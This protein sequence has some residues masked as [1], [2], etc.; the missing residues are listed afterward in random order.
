MTLY[1]F[2]ASGV[3]SSIVITVALNRVVVEAEKVNL[4][5]ISYLKLVPQM[6]LVFTQKI[7]HTHGTVL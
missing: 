6:G 3:S 1:S 7:R 4:H 5:L 2:S